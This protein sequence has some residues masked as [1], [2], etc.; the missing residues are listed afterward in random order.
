MNSP[1]N[2]PSPPLEGQP[3]SR[4][5]LFYIE[6][7]QE[8]IKS[9]IATLNNLLGQFLSLNI[10]L[11]GGAA[12]FLNENNFPVYLRNFAIIVLFFGLAFAFIGILPTESNVQ[13]NAPQQIKEHKNN[14]F[15]RKR[16]FMWLS[17]ICT[18]IGLSIVVLGTIKCQSI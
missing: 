2:A 6:W 12:F 11:L 7:A 1:D 10:G 16:C 18:G 15:K 9:N 14:A 13:S 3:P 5:D 8:T 17:A 4:E